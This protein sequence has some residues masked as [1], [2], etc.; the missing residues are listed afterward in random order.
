MNVE[1]LKVLKTAYLDIFLAISPEV[2]DNNI[3]DPHWLVDFT[4]GETCF[5]IYVTGS[6]TC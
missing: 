1:Q 4:R 3:K 6:F 5:F 2:V